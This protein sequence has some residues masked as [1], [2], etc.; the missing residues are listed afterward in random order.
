MTTYLVSYDLIAP[1]K[2][3]DGLIAH[4]NKFKHF[5]ILKS[6]WIIVADQTAVQ[7]RNGCQ[8]FMDVNDKIMVVKIT[9]PGAW[10]NIGH[11]D[12]LKENIK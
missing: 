6:Q 12:W 3:Y 7:L 2:N 9:A 1:G 10:N 5:H 11:D 8:Q 4:L